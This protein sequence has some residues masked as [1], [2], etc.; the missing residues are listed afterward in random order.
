MSVEISAINGKMKGGMRKRSRRNDF[1][2]EVSESFSRDII[3]KTWGQD[4][5]SGSVLG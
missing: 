5:Q 3:F 4:T 2:W 1:E